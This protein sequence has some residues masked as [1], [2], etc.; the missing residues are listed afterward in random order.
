[1][2]EIT[3][4][5]N[6]TTALEAPLTVAQ[7]LSGAA[8]IQQVLKSVMIAK[9]HFDVIPGCGPKPVLLKPGAEK[10]LATFR[11]AVHPEIEDLSSE[12]ESRYRILAKGLTPNGMVVGVGVGEA[13][14]YE[15]KWKWRAAVCQAEYDA[16][17]PD[18]RRI[19]FSKDNSQLKQVRT[20]C[21]DIAN[22]VLKMAKKRALVDLC[23]TATAASDVFAQ[24]LSDLSEELRQAV[25]AEDS[26]PPI[27]QPKRKSEGQQ[28]ASTP[29]TAPPAKPAPKP[30]PA[31]AKPVQGEVIPPAATPGGADLSFD[32]VIPADESYGMPAMP[33]GAALD[34]FQVY[35]G[36]VASYFCADKAKNGTPYLSQD[37]QPQKRHSV[38]IGKVWYSTFNADIGEYAGGLKGKDVMVWA[39]EKTGKDGRKFFTIE[40]IQQQVNA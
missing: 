3:V 16:A 35:Q 14:S 9:V 39:S 13:S 37:G 11:I 18:R 12:D 21:E 27:Q 2:N 38:S 15:Q 34:D 5:S 33:E 17:L 4:A 24:D 19:K 31:A 22:T 1:M 30:S 40:R 8:L 36:I 26:Q 32:G 28:P 6:H 20:D 29:R 10:I 23:L 7:V 25:M